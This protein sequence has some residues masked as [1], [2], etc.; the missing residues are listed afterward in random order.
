M[1]RN[2][3]ALRS[4]EIPGVHG[5]RTPEKAAA[6]KKAACEMQGGLSN[7][8]GGADGARTRDLQRDRLAF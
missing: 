8:T 6:K 1:T 2:F 4:F 3:K 7:P 5:K